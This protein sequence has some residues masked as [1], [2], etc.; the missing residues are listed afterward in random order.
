MITSVDCLGQSSSPFFQTRLPLNQ[1]DT[2]HNPAEATSRMLNTEQPSN[3]SEC[4]S[5]K[6]AMP[7]NARFCH[8]CGAPV[9][10]EPVEQQ[11]NWKVISLFLVGVGILSFGSIFAAL[12][13]ATSNNEVQSNPQFS[14]RGPAAPSGQPVD[15]STMTPREAADRLF[16]RVMAADERGDTEEAMQFAPMALQAYDLVDRLDADAHYHVG[17]IS[18]LVGNLGETRKQIESLESEVPDHLLGLILAFKIAENVGDDQAASGIRARFSA[19]YD[20][21]IN[22]GRP[23]YEAHLVTIESFRES[24]MGS[25]NAGTSGQMAESAEHGAQIYA[26]KCAGCHGPDS[27]GSDKG[28]PLVHQIYKSSHHNDASFYRAVRQGVQSHHWSFGDMPPIPGVTD[29][30][31]GNIVVYVRAL[32]LNSGIN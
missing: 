2:D 9:G 11:Q 15:L 32:Q 6:V 16:N 25:K 27:S 31:I 3:G 18:L 26:I 21:Q 5:C 14:G 10:N 23:E 8:N 24:T 17:L 22:A 30:Q 29:D 20:E 28:P 12:K 4:P 7:P 19:A 1:N 13:F